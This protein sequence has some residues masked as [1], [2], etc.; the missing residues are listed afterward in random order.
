MKK[1]TPQFCG[2]RVLQRSWFWA[3]KHTLDTSGLIPVWS[4]T[5]MSLVNNCPEHC[6][7]GVPPTGQ[8]SFPSDKQEMNGQCNLRRK[9]RRVFALAVDGALHWLHSRPL[10]ERLGHRRWL[11]SVLLLTLGSYSGGVEL[12]KAV[13]LCWR[14]FGRMKGV[15][16]H[17]WKCRCFV[18]ASDVRNEERVSVF[19]VSS[20]AY[21]GFSSFLHF[22]E[23]HSS[24]MF[25]RRWGLSNPQQT[26]WSFLRG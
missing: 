12:P 1:R 25:Q 15:S 9:Q 20:E 4:L 18:I 26:R 7:T 6:G 17:K 5:A 19:S 23:L 16:S 10:L 13:Y 14:H 2:D 22:L 3:E 11:C 24:E 21:H 8:D